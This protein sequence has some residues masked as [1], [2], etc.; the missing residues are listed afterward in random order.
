MSER[1]SNK[2]GTKQNIYRTVGEHKVVENTLVS[3]A[4]QITY[5]KRPNTIRVD[6]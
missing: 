4:C 6:L 5:N 3:T 2:D 1:D